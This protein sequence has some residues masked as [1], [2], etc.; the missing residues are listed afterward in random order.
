MQIGNFLGSLYE[1]ISYRG[2]RECR[3]NF[4]LVPISNIYFGR[5][6]F[7]AIERGRFTKMQKSNVLIESYTLYSTKTACLRKLVLK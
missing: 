2:S 3:I 6:L 4:H 1:N 5:A 7:Y